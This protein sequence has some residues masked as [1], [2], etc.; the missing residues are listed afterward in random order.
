MKRTLIGLLV[1]IFVADSLVH[2][3]LFSIEYVAIQ[4]DL[5][6]LE[7]QL[8]SKKSEQIGRS[9]A[10]IVLEDNMRMRGDVYSQNFFTEEHNGTIVSYTIVDS[11]QLVDFQK[12]T[13]KS[14]TDPFSSDNH[15]LFLKLQKDLFCQELIDIAVPK[16]PN[17][18]HKAS[19]SYLSP[20]TESFL[21]VQTPPPN[22][23]II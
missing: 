14:N 4:R 7:A 6:D 22:G 11:T 23:V 10:I 12:I 13:K 20:K 5:T 16:L 21:T 8:S 19:L 17:E 2:P 18:K 3:L 1:L 15:N 9:Q